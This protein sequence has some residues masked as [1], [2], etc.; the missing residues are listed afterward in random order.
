MPT[1]TT[2]NHALFQAQRA[3]RS[4]NDSDF[5]TLMRSVEL[6]VQAQAFSRQGLQYALRLPLETTNLMT[7]ALEAMGI[8][9]GG[10]SERRTVLT[11]PDRLTMLLAELHSVRVAEAAA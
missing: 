4:L 2:Q 7:E 9:V 3:I 6:V 1:L 8:I 11:P 10:P 5:A